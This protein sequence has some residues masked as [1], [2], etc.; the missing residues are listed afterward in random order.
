MWASFGPTAMFTTPPA[1]HLVGF[2]RVGA[3]ER[4]PDV[5]TG[6][7]AVAVTAARAGARVTALDL[8]PE[9]LGQARENA[10]IA[11]LDDIAW[12]EGDAERL[13]FPDASF[14]LVLSQFG[15]M[16]APRPDI[17]IAEM[18]RVL[19]PGGRVAFATWPPEHFVG[20]LLAFVG[21]HAPPPPAG[22]APP[23]Q[24]GN[25]AL[26]GERL[27]EGFDAPFFERGTM[28]VPP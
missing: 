14:D 20:R 21:R 3:S 26:V 7:G 11:G 2:A 19:T 28:T 13:P 17:A 5:G 8:T 10:R 27:A 22:V 4:V 23:G 16:F 6:T 9:L 15:H 18:R 12:T 1:A 25:P 24:W